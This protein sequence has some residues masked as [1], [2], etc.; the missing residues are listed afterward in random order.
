MR[1]RARHRNWDFIGRTAE[2]LRPVLSGG[3]GADPTSGWRRPRPGH[4]E[5]RRR[6]PRRHD[7]LPERS[8]SR[9]RSRRAIAK[10]RRHVCRPCGVVTP[11][12][13]RTRLASRSQK[14][15]KETTRSDEWS[16]KK[17]FLLA[18]DRRMNIRKTETAGARRCRG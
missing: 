15:L 10:H 4:R 11:Y 16:A 8:R 9:H 2:Y 12:A 18:R 6:R 14:L 13:L 17:M 5:T 7:Y 1:R 3:Q